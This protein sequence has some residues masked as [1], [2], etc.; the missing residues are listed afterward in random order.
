MFSQSVTQSGMKSKLRPIELTGLDCL[1]DALN[2][3]S[4]LMEDVEDDT[5]RHAINRIS[6]YLLRL[7]P[8]LQSVKR[9]LCLQLLSLE[10][11]RRH[12]THQTTARRFKE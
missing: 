5:N 4:I 10:R 9:G 6:S 1:N 2:A 7:S 12:S 3:L 8:I 11:I